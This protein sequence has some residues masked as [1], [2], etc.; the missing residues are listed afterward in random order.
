MCVCVCVCLFV[1]CVCVCVYIF[2]G[3][4]LCKRTNPPILSPTEVSTHLPTR[5]SISS[6]IPLTQFFD[7]PTHPNQPTNRLNHPAKPTNRLNHPAKPTN[8]LNH[9]AKPT[10]RLN[11][12]AKPTNVS[13][14]L[15]TNQPFNHSTNPTNFYLLHL[16][17]YPPTTHP[18][19]QRLE[20]ATMA[21]VDSRDKVEKQIQQLADYEAEV[22]LIKRRVALLE[23]DREQNKRSLARLQ[24]CLNRA[25]IVSCA[26][27]VGWCGVV[28]CGV[29]WCGVVWCGVVW[30]GVVWCGVVWCGVVWCDGVW[31][32]AVGVG[33]CGVVW[34]GVM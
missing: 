1:F 14:F 4:F 26:V 9:P 16:P 30:C 12:P 24:D 34:C 2:V 15:G 18:T 22:N 32:G 10:N 29:V 8:R 28:W 33:W 27:G 17:F 31:C 21:V 20:E 13:S 19:F 7:H 11:H 25:R 3:M 6:K 23:G 5:S